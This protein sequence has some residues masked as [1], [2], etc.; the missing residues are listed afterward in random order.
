M[1]E[2]GNPSGDSSATLIFAS[3]LFHLYF[4][5]ITRRSAKSI[6]ILWAFV[7]YSLSISA[8]SNKQLDSLQTL[9][10]ITTHNDTLKAT[11]LGQIARIYLYDFNNIEKM[12]QYATQ[13]IQL[14][15]K[16]NFKKGLAP[17]Y[18]YYGVYY[19]NMANYKYAMTY[20]LKALKLYE[21]LKDIKALG[22][23]YINI[24]SIYGTQGNYKNA[25][26]YMQKG[27]SYKAAANDKKGTSIAFNNIGNMY[28][29]QGN[30]P[31]AIS[32]L[33][34]S[35]KI[36]EEIKDKSG[37]SIAYNNIGLILELQGKTE[38]AITYHNK[39]LKLKEEL[40]DRLG[41]SF[42]YSNLATL[43]M[44]QK[45]Y[46]EA[47]D[48]NFKSL[49]IKEE[50]GDKQGEALCLGNIGAI[51][52][53]ENKTKDALKYQ[54]K[55]L[56][57]MEDIGDAKDLVTT[58]LGLGSTYEKEHFYP[59]ALIYYD[60]ALKKAIEID[61]RDGVRQAYGSLSSVY[62]I[63]KNYQKAL[64]YTNLFYH[65]KDSLF[66]KEAMK[67]VT[68]INTKYQTEKK[69]QE[70][71]LLTKDQQLKDKTLREQRVI[72][73]AL[74]VGLALFFIL[75]FTLYNRYR[76]KQKANTLLEK[77]KKEIQEQNVLI[78]DSIDY[79][80]TIQEAVF[81][82]EKKMTK[83]FPDSFVLYK[84]KAIVSGDFY[85]VG[86]KNDKL[87][88]TVADCTGHGIP[89][90]FM[91]LLGFNMLE[92]IIE[93]KENYMPS[94]ILNELNQK[95]VA[96]MSQ[97]AEHITSVKHG[98]DA[99]VITIDKQ[100]M[101]LQ[102]AGAHNPLYQVRDNTLTEIKADKMSIGSYKEG[103]QV[104]FQNHT[105]SIQK[106][107]V[108]Y[109]FSDGFPDQIGGPNRKKFYYPPFKELLVSIHKM[110]MAEQKSFLDGVITS[111]KG[112]RDQTDDILVVGIKI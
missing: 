60:K 10:K 109:L 80:K 111:W 4:F 49:K 6:C 54:L 33:M 14:S 15:Q 57:I 58:S 96:T 42:S 1:S 87:I 104:E 53:S 65:E 101:Q 99:S 43:Y 78:T 102:F 106:G 93:K 46:K 26:A 47:Q 108:F 51:Y 98:M 110:A 75:S 97:D 29:D 28:S 76:F 18:L 61:Y 32:Y 100:T 86:E 37:I 27:A 112:E 81:P 52:T 40:G 48:Y 64:E 17:G 19:N 36:K 105:L 20:Y 83:L 71:Q 103:K 66:N 79:A 5:N 70:I 41:A 84:P 73:I 39:S 16:S 85:L 74:I 23:C 3:P 24:G 77:Q 13:A 25:L 35:L 8:Q 34:K 62:T 55:A 72:R 63:Q 9:L 67:Q 21:E 30:Y 7:F 50:L 12:K 44:N 91:S 45:K 92:N 11:I 68:E 69:E 89:G 2:N 82:S 38:E 59:E 94:D 88:C 95:M 90:A 107:D 56:K 22:S 31:Q